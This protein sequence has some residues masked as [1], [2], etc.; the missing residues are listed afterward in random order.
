MTTKRY[1]TATVLETLLN[2]FK[3]N[4]GTSPGLLEKP[5]YMWALWGLNGLCSGACWP[6]IGCLIVSNFPEHKRGQ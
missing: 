4:F 2:N 6:A 5:E 3:F 1:K